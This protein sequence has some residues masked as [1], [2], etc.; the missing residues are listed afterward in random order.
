MPRFLS[1]LLLICL[2]SSAHAQP[3][4]V[5][6][7]GD[8]ED[9]RVAALDKAIG[10]WNAELS[11]LGRK[12]RLELA[13]FT[14]SPVPVGY[15]THPKH[16][17]RPPVEA[18]IS[19]DAI[20]GD[21]LVALPDAHFVSFALVLLDERRFVAI[22][23]LEHPALKAVGVAENLIAHEL[24]HALG[25]IHNDDAKTLM[26]GA[27]SPCRPDRFGERQGGFYPLTDKDRARLRLG[28]EN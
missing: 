6:V 20:P 10:F 28:Q 18:P 22:R 24:G 1:A 13:G 26:C 25:L 15:Y 11:A 27:P 16:N 2:A 8:R 7:L 4:K 14:A 23:S 3:I 19:L 5:T 17:G 21:I 12:E 9:P